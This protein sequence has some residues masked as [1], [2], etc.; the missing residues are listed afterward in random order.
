MKVPEMLIYANAFDLSP[1]NG[2]TDV[3]FKVASWASNKTN[4]TILARELARGVGRYD[5]ANRATLSSEATTTDNDGNREWSYPFSWSM[6]LTH[7]DAEIKGRSWTV[8][9]GLNQWSPSSKVQFTIVLRMEE[10]SAAVAAPVVVTRPTI[11]RELI[12][13]CSPGVSTPGLK[14]KI[15]TAGE[16]AAAYLQ[17]VERNSRRHPLLVIS[18]LGSSN[19]GEVERIRDFLMGLADVVVIPATENTYE[20]QNEVGRDYIAFGGAMRLIYPLPMRAG[21]ERAWSKVFLPE[22]V[23]AMFGEAGG[24]ASAVLKRMTAVTNTRMQQQ[25]ITA[26]WVRGRRIALQMKALRV[27]LQSGDHRAS[28]EELEQL[29]QLASDQAKESSETAELEKIARLEAIE[30]RDKMQA[31]AAALESQLHELR[32]KNSATQVFSSNQLTG[33]KKAAATLNESRPKLF[34]VLCFIAA[35]FPSELEVLEAAYESAKESDR[36]GFSLGRDALSLLLRLG[37]VYA[38]GLRSGQTEQLAGKS[39]GKNELAWNEGN[40]LSVAGRSARTFE[41]AGER[42]FME[43]HL[44][45]GAKD[46]VAET[47][48]IHFAWNAPN[49]KVVIGHCGKHLNR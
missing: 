38:T 27:A 11:V 49:R 3:I 19:Y 29:F 2:P 18:D 46:S 41:Y 14:V 39:F 34:D 23:D 43:R 25:H 48:R 31:K 5:A 35:I 44:K 47:L 42:I 33:I 4:T 15:L 6:T 45:A 36:G 9:Y 13:D 12:Q 17:E 8:E 16:A 20:L 24:I 40:E 7:P 37:Y 28:S 32:Q 30:E 1:A 22:E 26:N 21:G 10:S